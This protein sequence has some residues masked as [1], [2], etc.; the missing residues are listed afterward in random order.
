MADVTNA[1]VPTGNSEFDVPGDL[2]ALAD[3][4]GDSEFY[5]RAT[6]SGFPPADNW[7]GRLMLARDT[8]TLYRWFGSSWVVSSEDTGWLTPTLT[9]PW[10]AVSGSPV[11]YRRINGVVYM[12][13]RVQGGTPGTSF[14]TLPAGFRPAQSSRFVVSGGSGG[15]FESVIVQTSGSV[16]VSTTG[17]PNLTSIIFPVG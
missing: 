16:E 9:S 4:F 15:S 5:S 13:G 17:Q 10:T 2:Q 7:Q 6:A 1:P 14:C 11:G 12:R 8:G 3:H